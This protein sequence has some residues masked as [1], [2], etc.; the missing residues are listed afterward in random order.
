MID[1]GIL[2]TYLWWFYFTTNLCSSINAKKLHILHWNSYCCREIDCLYMHVVRYLLHANAFNLILLHAKIIR[3]IPK[4]L[5]GN[6][7]MFVCADCISML[8]CAHTYTCIL[9]L[10]CI[11][12]ASIHHKVFHLKLKAFIIINAQY[13]RAS[14]C[15]REKIEHRIVVAKWEKGDN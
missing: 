12:Y 7:I 5:H 3:L 10:N 1:A 13:A 15:S 4:T 6:L 2:L 8:Q 14:C 11:I 9:H